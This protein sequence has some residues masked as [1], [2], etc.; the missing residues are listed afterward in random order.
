MLKDESDQL[1]LNLNILIKRYAG[2]DKIRNIIMDEFNSRNMKAS[3][4]VSILT[5]RKLLSTI[6]ISIKHELILLFVFTSGMFKALTHKELGDKDPLGEASEWNSIVLEDYFTPIEVENLSDYKKEKKEGKKEEVV[7]HNMVQVSENQWVGVI[8]AKYLAELDADNEFIYNFKTQRDPI[9]DVLGMKRIRLDKTKVGQITERLLSGE[10][11][12]DAIGINI[13]HDGTD[14]IKFEKNGD[15]TV[16]SG[17][18]NIFDGM[19]RKVS[20]SLALDI[21][22][23]LEFNWIIMVTNYN[24]IKAQRAMVQINKQKPMRPEHVKILDTTKLGNVVI[25][26]IKDSNFEFSTQIRD[27]DDE[28][29]HSGMAKKATLAISVEEVFKDRLQNRLQ[30]KPIAKHIAEVVDYIMGL[31]VEEFIIHPEETKKVSY[32][33]HKNMFAG[34]VALSAK[35]YG[36]KD[37]EDKIEQAL[38]KVDFGVE[39]P[40]WKDCGILDHDMKKASRNNLYKFFYNLI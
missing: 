40:F 27:S 19:H 17:Q 15:L 6:D 33:N 24:E 5:E 11:F 18:K 16:F 38:D 14:E 20:T 36:D 1:I 29:K 9:I 4:A 3:I 22:G 37:W 31:N 34:Y 13:L 30:A 39:N 10:Q 28:L 23:D 7:F 12:P 32:I 25:D 26:V 35:L 2:N 8:S 21:N